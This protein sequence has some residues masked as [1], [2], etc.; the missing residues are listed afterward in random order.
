MRVDVV[1][2]AGT[3][4]CANAQV[5]HPVHIYRDISERFVNVCVEEHYNLSLK[6]FWDIGMDEL[7]IKCDVFGKKVLSS[8]VFFFILNLNRNQLSNYFQLVM[9]KTNNAAVKKYFC[10]YIEKVDL[11]R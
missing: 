10:H 3:S 9:V 1:L 4:I 6:Y 11:L 8:H 2:F 5:N 7:T